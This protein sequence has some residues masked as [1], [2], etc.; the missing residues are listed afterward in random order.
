MEGAKTDPA[1]A[2]RV[3]S[4]RPQDDLAFDAEQLGDIPEASVLLGTVERPVDR[5]EPLR[6][7]ACPA[8][9]IRQ[10]AEELIVARMERGLGE[11]IERSAQHVQSPNRVATLDQENAPEATT[12][13]MPKGQSMP[14]RILE[15]HR[16]E[17][18]RSVEIAGEQGHRAGTL[19]ER[20][21]QCH[22]MIRSQ[23][24]FDTL[25]S[26]GDSL[27]GAPLK[28]EDR[29]EPRTCRHPRI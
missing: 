22:R 2:R 5:R 27:V 19:S 6:D 23:S 18:L 24:L 9:R 3:A 28:P 14:L 7:A 29:R 1:L 17:G 15:Q 25:L 12:V 20:V 26:G 13:R 16:D 11:L 21:T 10:F 8:Q 4:A